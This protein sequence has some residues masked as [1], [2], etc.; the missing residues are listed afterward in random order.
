MVVVPQARVM[1]PVFQLKM[2]LVLRVTVPGRP[3]MVPV[4]FLIVPCIVDGKPEQQPP[5]EDELDELDRLLELDELD[6][7][8]EQ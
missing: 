8:E 1:L 7:D 6:E 3:V 5:D 4:A 2:P